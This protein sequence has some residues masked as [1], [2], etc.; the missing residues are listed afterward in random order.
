MKDI[1]Q[2]A[3]LCFLSDI[4]ISIWSYLKLTN[5]DEYLKLAKPIIGSPDLEIQLYQILIQS[6]TFTLLLFL[7]F[8]LAI[9]LLLW[10]KKA[11]SIKYLR[12][13][14]FTAAI[15]CLLMIVSYGAYL[16]IIPLA[17]YILSFITLGKTLKSMQSA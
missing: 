1:K 11:Y 4:G 17:I 10:K 14:T 16:T 5:Y 2:V 9:Y 15:S 13:Y 8:H 12:F 7:F 6:F 3:V